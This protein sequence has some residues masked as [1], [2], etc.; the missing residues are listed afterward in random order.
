[1]SNIFQADNLDDEQ[2]DYVNNEFFS[3]FKRYKNWKTLP[4]KLKDHLP[5]Y[6][7]DK[8]LLRSKVEENTLK[9]K[10][11]INIVY[12]LFSE[13][14]KNSKVT[15]NMERLSEINK[16]H[17]KKSPLNEQQ[18]K[19]ISAYLALVNK[20]GTDSISSISNVYKHLE[21][22]HQNALNAELHLRQAE[23]TL[24]LCVNLIN[25][26][27]DDSEGISYKKILK[28]TKELEKFLS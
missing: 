7:S 18:Q 2:L 27:I 21:Q 10:S 25:Q 19:A 14:P 8:V 24:S 17:S 3:G 12:S 1:M 23:N 28:E 22:Q 9:L 6:M 5:K 20:S 16:L 26:Y 15:D 11:L 13:I 4:P